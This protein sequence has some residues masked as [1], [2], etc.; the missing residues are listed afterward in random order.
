MATDTITVVPRVSRFGFTGIG[1]VAS[2]R[3]KLPRAEIQYTLVAEPIAASGAGDDRRVTMQLFPPPNFAYVIAELECVIYG[4]NNVDCGFNTGYCAVPHNIAGVA[5]KSV[6]F[7]LANMT[8]AKLQDFPQ[9][10]TFFATDLPNEIFFGLPG[11]TYFI[12]ANFMDP[13]N[14]GPAATMHFNMRLLQYD[15]SQVHHVAA[16]TPTLVR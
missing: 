10:Q 3:T 7:P 12:V 8:T 14:A 13:T 15:I 9:H 16:N 2:E 1:D 11:E 4:A 6:P 5:T